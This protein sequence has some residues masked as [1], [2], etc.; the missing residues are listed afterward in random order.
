MS[1]KRI[2]LLVTIIALHTIPLKAVSITNATL[3]L[4]TAVA[5]SLI[6]AHCT[7]KQY[8]AAAGAGLI[9]SG[10]GYC[11]YAALEN[12]AHGGIKTQWVS[13]IVT[14]SVTG[15]VYSYIVAP[16]KCPATSNCN[17]SPI[18]CARC[19]R[20]LTGGAFF[21]ALSMLIGLLVK[22]GVN[23]MSSSQA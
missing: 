5:T 8:A 17:H 14:A 19:K 2:V 11:A 3:C 7:T 12:N 6:G 15:L 9:T 4:L 18:N 21:G 23:R 22:T 10:I 1:K 16:S 20:L 13:S